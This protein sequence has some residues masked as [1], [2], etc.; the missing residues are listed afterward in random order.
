MGRLEYEF[1]SIFYF[2]TC[3]MELGTIIYYW[4]N[5]FGKKYLYQKY[6]NLSRD[7]NLYALKTSRN[8]EYFNTLG[9]CIIV[10]WQNCIIYME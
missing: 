6:R 2:E 10:T 5:C 7:F 1:N 8:I 9:N 3:N 4:Y